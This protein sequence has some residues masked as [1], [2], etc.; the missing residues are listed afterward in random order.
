MAKKRGLSFKRGTIAQKAASKIAEG[1]KRSG[2][3]VNPHAAA[4]ARVKKMK[5]AARRKTAKKR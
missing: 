5:P 3:A 1:I 2:G 4:R